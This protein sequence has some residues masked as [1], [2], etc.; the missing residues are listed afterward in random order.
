MP[1][2][3]PP[4][5]AAIPPAGLGTRFLPAT[6]AVDGP[7][8][9]YTV[10]EAATACVAAGLRAPV[11]AGAGKPTHGVAPGEREDH[12]RAAERVACWPDIGLGCRRWLGDVVA[13]PG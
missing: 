9:Q 13:G 7:A 12:L 10:E 4:P 3:R 2:V 8:L 5:Q 1:T 6:D 11:R